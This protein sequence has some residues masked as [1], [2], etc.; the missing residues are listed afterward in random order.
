MMNINLNLR[1]E[2][3]G[4]KIVSLASKM[5]YIRNAIKEG[6]TLKFE[7]VNWEGKQATRNV[8]PI[9]MYYGNNKYHR[10]DQYLLKAIDLDK[11]AE[12]N[13]SVKD[14]LGFYPE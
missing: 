6:R 7:Y 2:I 9:I 10:T 12:R 8:K 3:L 5:R 4:S 11:N 1:N 13:F 14:I